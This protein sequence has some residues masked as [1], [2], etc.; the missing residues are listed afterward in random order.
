MWNGL[1]V[2]SLYTWQD[3]RCDPNFLATLPTPKSH[4]QAFSGYGCNTIFWF[5][6]NRSDIMFCYCSTITNLGLEEEAFS[7]S[8]QAIMKSWI[9]LSLI[10]I[11]L[12]VK[13]SHK[14]LLI[15]FYCVFFM[16]RNWLVLMFLKT[17]KYS[18]LFKF[19]Y[20][21]KTYWHIGE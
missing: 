6:R 5:A 14:I 21:I 17:L 7:L 15:L 18:N 11:P 2:S 13:N 10:I 3:S 12:S 1:Q 19:N 8:S 4:L 20:W 16:F 9:L